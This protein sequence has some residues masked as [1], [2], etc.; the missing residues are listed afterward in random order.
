MIVGPVTV[1]P[2]QSLREALAVMREHNI[3]GVPVVEGDHPVGILTARDIRF[4]LVRIEGGEI[5]FVG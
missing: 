3:S 4:G 2:S 1:R 5:L